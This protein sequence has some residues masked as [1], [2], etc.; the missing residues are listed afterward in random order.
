MSFDIVGVLSACCVNGWQITWFLYSNHLSSFGQD[1]FFFPCKTTMS[2]VTVGGNYLINWWFLRVMKWENPE[3]V[4][5][6][7]WESTWVHTSWLFKW[8]ERVQ[9]V[10][11]TCEP[12][13]R[14]CGILSLHPASCYVRDPFHHFADWPLMLVS[15]DGHNLVHPWIRPKCLMTNLAV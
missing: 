4:N 7:W 1:F 10:Q 8:D 15:G 6:S 3:G 2:E 14:S 9:W 11:G 13:S 12:R 5:K